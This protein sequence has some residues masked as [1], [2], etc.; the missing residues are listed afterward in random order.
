MVNFKEEIKIKLVN[1]P[2][3]RTDIPAVVVGKVVNANAYVI[4]VPG[5]LADELQHM[6]NRYGYPIRHL[7]LEWGKFF[8]TDNEFIISEEDIVEV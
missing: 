6:N 4:L 5:L 2:Y 8:G 1:A 3:N 7:K